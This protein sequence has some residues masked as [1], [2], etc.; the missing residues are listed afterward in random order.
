MGGFRVSVEKFRNVAEGGV[1]DLL[2]FEILRFRNSRLFEHIDRVRRLGVN[3][4]DELDRYL[5]VAAAK[6]DRCGI[7]ES[8]L[9]RAGG[10]LLHRV[11]R[12]L[13]A[14]DLN[15]E[16]LPGVVALFERDKIVRVPA[17]VAEIRDESYLI[18]G[19]SISLA[20]DACADRCN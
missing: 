15:I 11:R 13:S 5:V 17:V 9:R 8:D 3:D 12:S 4:R 10:N 1:G 20:K 7:G 6:N 2:A 16:V 14:H 19:S 18:R